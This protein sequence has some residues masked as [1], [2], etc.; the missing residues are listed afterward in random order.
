MTSWRDW[1]AEF[2]RTQKLIQKAGKRWI[3]RKLT[4]SFNSW[5]M[6][7]EE[8]KAVLNRMK[9]AMAR[10]LNRQL[11]MAYGKWAEWYSIIKHEQNMLKKVTNPVCPGNHKCQANLVT[12]TLQP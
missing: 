4:A 7:Y 3:N 9:K 2:R 10:F 11:S 12:L 6:W 1:L 5:V 8:R